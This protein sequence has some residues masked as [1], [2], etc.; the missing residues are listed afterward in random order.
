MPINGGEQCETRLD[1]ARWRNRSQRE[2][3]RGGGGEREN[4][5]SIANVR[6]TR[7]FLR[8]WRPLPYDR[9]KITGLPGV[10]WGSCR[11]TAILR[12]PPTTTECYG[13]MERGILCERHANPPAGRTIAETTGC[14]ANSKNWRSQGDKG[15][16]RSVFFYF[17]LILLLVLASPLVRLLKKSDE[18][19]ERVRRID[20]HLW[21][22]QRELWS[23]R[24]RFRARKI[25]CIGI[26]GK[27]DLT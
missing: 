18:S 17:V 12:A 27:V 7:E 21:R 25:I 10:W 9:G 24:T 13:N 3:G 23:I 14:P 11:T 26:Y 5:K 22:G 6:T 2:R 8:N 1:H 20:T 19:R 16:F 15:Y 4:E